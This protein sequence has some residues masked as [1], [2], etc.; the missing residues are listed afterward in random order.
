MP[1]PAK[2]KYCIVIN[3]TMATLPQHQ[4]NALGFIPEGVH[5]TN[6]S[7]ERISSLNSLVLPNS[8]YE[9][10]TTGSSIVVN[11][12]TNTVIIDVPSTIATLTLAFPIRPHDGK[13]LTISINIEDGG[14]ITNLTFTA[15]IGGDTLKSPLV[16]P[17]S[18]GTSASWFYRLADTTWYPTSLSGQT[19][20]FKGGNITTSRVLTTADS[21]T[22]F[23]V[24]IT[25]STY[26]ITLPVVAA[27]LNFRFLLVAT[28]GTVYTRIST[29][30]L[31]HMYG[32]IVE[33]TPDVVQIDGEHNI[34]FTTAALTG[35]SIDFWGIDSTHWLVRAVS[36]GTNGIIPNTPP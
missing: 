2:L 36:S 8:Q 3:Q 33:G 15:P 29:P 9:T 28:A 19:T 23:G 1:N 24:T 34:S 12:L 26:E 27:G 18:S 7:V 32:T 14:E 16:S 17:I 25:S 6:L 31:L 10:P 4:H 22:T 13:V 20:A 11:D 5:H 21:N 35:D 30:A